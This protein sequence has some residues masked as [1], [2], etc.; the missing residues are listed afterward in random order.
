MWILPLG[1]LIVFELVA[2]V[3]AKEWSLHGHAVRWIGAIAAYVIANTFW[4][5]ALRQG[6][7][8]ARG[9]IIFSVATA[10]I[11]ASLGLFL[12]KENLTRLQIIGVLIGIVSLVLIFWEGR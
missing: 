11:A 10:I 8:L 12:Y 1:L 5:I 7:G 2:D 3:L 6:S 9:A 4:L